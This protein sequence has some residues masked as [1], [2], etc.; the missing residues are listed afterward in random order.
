MKKLECP[1]CE[2]EIEP[3]SLF[4]KGVSKNIFDRIIKIPG[5]SK[6]KTFYNTMDVE[7]LGCPNCR[8]I[9]FDPVI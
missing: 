4:M 5:V 1:N 8:I 7:F 2:E 6:P 3:I 9:F